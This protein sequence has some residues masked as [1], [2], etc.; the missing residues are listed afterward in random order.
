VLIGPTYPQVFFDETDHT[1]SMGQASTF[2][3][4]RFGAPVGVT[5]APEDSQEQR[6]SFLEL[7]QSAHR[8]G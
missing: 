7:G 5:A 6:A 4:P 3:V 8:E 1:L 2:L